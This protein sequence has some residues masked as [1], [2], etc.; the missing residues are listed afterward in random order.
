MRD[1]AKNPEP[2]AGGDGPIHV[3]RF[4]AASAFSFIAA[5]HLA[6]GNAGQA[7]L[8]GLVAAAQWAIAVY[9]YRRAVAARR[10]S[11]PSTPDPAREE[12]TE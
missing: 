5:I 7:L 8:W 12:N 10:R 9:R 2:A 6:R 11:S 3:I 1:E 4:V